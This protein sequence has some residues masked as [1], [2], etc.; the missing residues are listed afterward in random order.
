[1][2]HCKAHLCCSAPPPLEF[3]AILLT[4]L[5]VLYRSFWL[6]FFVYFPYEIAFPKSKHLKEYN[7]TKDHIFQIHY[8]S[9]VSLK[10][11]F[12][13]L[14]QFFESTREKKWI[15]RA[16][17]DRVTEMTESTL[18]TVA[19]RRGRGGRRMKGCLSPVGAAGAGQPSH[20]LHAWRREALGTEHGTFHVSCYQHLSRALWPWHLW[21]R[22]HTHFAGKGSPHAHYLFY[23][24]SQ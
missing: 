15:P 1:M 12:F 23:L 20:P 8:P 7:F 11:N 9:I 3:R 10:F 21:V 6:Q 24:G 18:S 2:P 22:A 17:S 19:G 4:L 5:Y 16:A 13:D 14:L